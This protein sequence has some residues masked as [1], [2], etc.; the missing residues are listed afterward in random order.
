[1][2]FGFEIFHIFYA[3]KRPFFRFFDDAIHITEG[4]KITL[5]RLGNI[6][7]KTKKERE[8]GSFIFTAEYNPED[9]VYKGT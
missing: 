9:N 8:N 5:M 6:Y 3:K 1:M 7:I 4:E 2:V